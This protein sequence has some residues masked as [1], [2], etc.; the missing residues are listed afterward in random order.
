MLDF[1]CIRDRCRQERKRASN[2]VLFINLLSSLF[3]LFCCVVGLFVFVS[4]KFLSKC[5]GASELD[6]EV[7]RFSLDS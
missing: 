4:F 5:G 6:F 7:A 3:V 1:L 2:A